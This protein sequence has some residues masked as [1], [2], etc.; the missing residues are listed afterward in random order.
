[1]PA[2]PPPATIPT[3]AALEHVIRT[4]RL[5]LRPWR[6]DDVDAIYP[7]VSDPRFPHQMSWAAHKDRSETVAFVES[8]AK[9]M[10]AG[11]NMMWAIEHE[12]RAGGAI[13]LDGILWTMRALRVDRAEV[14][15]WLAPAL[16]NRGI[17]T[18]A[19]QAVMRWAFDALRLNKL[20]IGCIEGNVGSRRVIEKSGFRYLCR[21]DDDVW[22]D[23]R[24]HAHLRW[25]L[26]AAE[27]SDVHT[28]LRV[29]R[30]QPT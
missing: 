30:P 10:E 5:V 8:A 14:G 15:Y 21:L 27:W 11:T 7:V 16:W 26:T 1:M 29:T 2:A 12:G 24:W 6:L 9:A 17:M 19:L 13:S 3:L 18:E 20:T 22:R 28:T 4:P 23:G 25:E